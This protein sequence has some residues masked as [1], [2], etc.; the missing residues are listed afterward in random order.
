MIGLG[1]AAF[2]ALSYWEIAWS[3]QAH[4]QSTQFFYLLSLYVFFSILE[5]FSYKKLFL[6]S[7]LTLAT[8]LSHFFGFFLLALYAVIFIIK[9]VRKDNQ[10][11]ILFFRKYKKNFL[12]GL[13]I[14]AIVVPILGALGYQVFDK[15]LNRSH[16]VGDSYLRFLLASIPIIAT[17]AVIGLVV[18][19]LQ[20]KK[21]LQALV[22]GLAYIIPYLSITFST[23]IKHFLIYFLVLP[24]L[25]ILSSYLFYELSRLFNSR[26]T[27]YLFSGLIGSVII[28]SII[29]SPTSFNLLPKSH[30]YLEQQTPQPNFAYVY[31]IIKTRGF[32][33]NDVIISPYTQM[34]KIYLGK[35][36]Y[37]LAIDLL[38]KDLNKDALPE[39]EFY[40][41]AQTIKDAEQLKKVID[42]NSGYLIVDDMARVRLDEEINK[43]IILLP[44]VYYELKKGGNSIWVFSF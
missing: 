14:L 31:D 38:G 40:T 25:F 3:R 37:W 1:A 4:V 22:L 26:T 2:T 23:D 42:N 20:K 13:L 32:L 36:D 16:F 18:F 6:L 10:R 24:I 15:I 41:N 29:F 44:I 34:D 8:I 5:K 28:V 39:R 30:Y 33:E 11:I 9:I 7:V 35:S 43:T 21:T 27:N 19:L 17:S 12:V